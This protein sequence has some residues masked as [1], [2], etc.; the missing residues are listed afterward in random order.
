MVV[1]EVLWLA[2]VGIAVAIP[3]ALLLSQGLR[4]QLYGISARDP[5]TIFAV[6]VLT[7]LVSGVA[8][9]LPARRA[10]SVDPMTALRYE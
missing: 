9:L 6:V 8:A 10:S 4:E 2:G 5:L 7:G 1:R 3:I